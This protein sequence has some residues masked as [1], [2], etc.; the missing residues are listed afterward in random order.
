MAD[1]YGLRTRDAAG[2]ITLDT[3]ITSVR[4]LKMMQVVGNGQFDQYVSIPEIKAE[5]FVVV[6]SL[7]SGGDNV[8]SPQAWYSPGQLQL[9]QPYTSTWQVMILS[10]GGEPFNAPGSFGIR[11]SNNSSRTQIDS[12][13]QI[14]SVLYNGRFN[15]GFQ[16]PGSANQIQWGDVDFP[17]P[18]TTYERPLVFLNADNYMMVG[19]FSVK[20]SPGNWTGFRLKAWNNQVAHGETAL[21]PMY[22]NWY[23]AS[24]R[25]GS[26][27][28]GAYGA[29]VR[30]PAGNRTFVTTA[31]LALLNG[32]PAANAFVQAGDPIVAGQ[33]YSPSFQMPWTG[34]YQDYVLANALF[35]VTNIGATA[36]PIRE[37]FGGFLPGNR[38]VLQMYTYNGGAINPVTP[39]GRTLF[40]SRPMKTL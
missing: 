31:N 35:S 16:G 21:Y 26:S 32:Q 30:D 18:I 25:A 3:T 36:N 39:N 7:Q 28:P 5:S 19:N 22:I 15:I 12:V 29:S 6:D 1:L 23:C 8:S 2:A 40:A 27:A 10:L 9:R 37:N 33:T 14:L 4:S 11:A 24:Y 17:A 34:S 20:G 13:N 38:S